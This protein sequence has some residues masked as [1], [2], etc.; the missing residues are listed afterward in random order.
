MKRY[1]NKELA[2]MNANRFAVNVLREEAKS[3]DPYHPI[4]K[5]LRETIAYLHLMEETGIPYS[6][7]S[8]IFAVWE[9]KKPSKHLWALIVFTEDSFKEPLSL[10]Q[11]AF[12]VNSGCRRFYPTDPDNSI[13]GDC[14]D[15]CG[16]LR[17]DTCM[18]AEKGGEQGWQVEGCYLLPADYCFPASFV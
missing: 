14:L 18:A 5:K 8:E 11:R 7:L 2:S 10:T 1:S 12:V 6:L 15:G 16:K 9:S 4:T 3:R 13:F 17:L